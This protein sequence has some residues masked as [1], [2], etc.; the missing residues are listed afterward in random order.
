MT[1][2]IRR[3][4][5]RLLVVLAAAVLGLILTEGRAPSD[6]SKW[7]LDLVVALS[8]FIAVVSALLSESLNS[9][10][11]EVRS[12]VPGNAARLLALL[13]PAKDYREVAGTIDELFTTEIVPK[14]GRK[15]GIL[16]YWVQ[17]LRSL[18]VILLRRALELIGLGRVIERIL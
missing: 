14:F 7:I 3:Y 9:T 2:R 17:I 5:G 11:A 6:F 13:V 18:P 15:F 4:C 8:I 1:E 12:S 16:W 10:G